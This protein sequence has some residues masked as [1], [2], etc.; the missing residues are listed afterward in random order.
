L[1]CIIDFVLRWRL[2]PRQSGY[3]PEMGNVMQITSIRV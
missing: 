1:G 3:F 2:H